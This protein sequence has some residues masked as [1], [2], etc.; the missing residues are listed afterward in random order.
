[1]TRYYSVI[2][3]VVFL[4]S[5]KEAP[6]KTA[7]SNDLPI[8]VEGVILSEF[9]TDFISVLEAHGS[10]K[11][12][13]K[14]RTLTF[15]I[16]K[17]EITETHTIDL[18]TRQDVVAAD[19]FSLGFD[20]KEIWLEDE[21]NDYKG[22]AA[23]YHNLMFYF[24][25]MPFVFA[26]PGINYEVAEPLL[27][28]GKE[29]PGIHISYDDGVGASSKDDYYLHY[30][31]ETFKMKWLGYT[32]TYGSNEKSKDVKWIHY[33][34]WVEIE[35]LLLPKTITWHDYEDRTIKGARDPLTFHKIG[36]AESPKI[37]TFYEKPENAKVVLKP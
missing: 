30:D 27:Y 10:L 3:I 37:P 19:K 23:V 36:L 31:P 28:E 22:N 8:E 20:G 24:Y 34:D 33:N 16:E 7:K 13:K 9:P 17:G 25:A 18:K 29:Y 12:W 5:C 4:I 26:D 21:N 6:S 1:M 2:I 32:F 15:E 35:G 14:Q 11:A